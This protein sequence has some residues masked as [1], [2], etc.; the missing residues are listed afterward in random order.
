MLLSAL[1]ARPE[2][3]VPQACETWAASKAAYR[4]WSNPQV[5][6]QAIQKGQ[7]GRTMERIES[8]TGGILAIQDTTYLVYTT[9]PATTGLGPLPGAKTEGK[10]PQGML[11]HSVLAVSQQGVPLGLLHQHVWVRPPEEVVPADLT[12]EQRKALQKAKRKQEDQR[13][14][15][16]KESYRWLSSVQAVEQHLT[17]QPVLVVGDREADIYELFVQPRRAGV[18]LLVRASED[19]LVFA[20]ERKLWAAARAAPVMGTQE[21]ALQAGNG[22]PARRAQVQ[23][24]LSAQHILAPAN[25]PASASASS[26][27][28]AVQLRVILVEEP[29][30]P[31]GQEAL[32]WLLL[33]TLPIADLAGAQRCIQWYTLRWLI[34][35]YHFVLKSGCRIEQLQLETAER[36]Q[37][38]LATFSVVAWRLLWLTYQARENP[39]ESCETVLQPHEWQALQA[40]VTKNAQVGDQPPCLQQAVRWIAQLGGFLARKS[41]GEPGVQTLWR[42]LRRLED[43]ASMWLL[44][45]STSG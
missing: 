3:S 5:T 15:E 8:E 36:L 43:L 12:K 21:V 37:R 9:H 16:E 17:T 38:A 18:E 10:A 29:D 14:I 45:H 11:V 7:A 22:R 40:A 39:Q 23:I 24:R 34:E 30:P 31:D 42:G 44:L 35:R 28:L 32:C 41:D 2:S 19:R 33:T 27:P 4:F 1:S 25:R 6:P 20:C 26:R 13:P